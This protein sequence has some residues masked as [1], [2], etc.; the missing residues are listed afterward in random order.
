[1]WDSPQL[2]SRARAALPPASLEMCQRW[3]SQVTGQEKE[4]GNVVQRVKGTKGVL[5]V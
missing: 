4:E 2:P 5:G 3:R 1:M